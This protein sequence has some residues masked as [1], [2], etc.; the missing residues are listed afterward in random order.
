MTRLSLI[1]IFLCVCMVCGAQEDKTSAVTGPAKDRL[2]VSLNLQARF[3]GD[4]IVLRWGCNSSFAWPILSKTGYWVER[5]MLDEN[6]KPDPLFTRLTPD[7]VRPWSEL[8]WNQKSVQNDLY[9]QVAEKAL[10]GKQFEV[11]AGDNTGA[12]SNKDRSVKSMQQ[13]ASESD[14]RFIAA[15][16]SGSFSQNA[17]TA[18]GLR[19]TDRNVRKNVKYVYRVYP[20][21]VSPLFRTDTAVFI[22]DTKNELSPAPVRYL[23]AYEGDKIISIRWEDPEHYAGYYIE[24]SEDGKVFNKLSETP[25]IQFGSEAKANSDEFTYLDTL[26]INYKNYYYRIRG[27]SLFSEVSEPSEIIVAKGRDREAPMQPFIRKSVYQGGKTAF[28]DWEPYSS[29]PDLLG[30]FVQRG[31][32]IKGPYI[33][34][35][36]EI[37]TPTTRNFTDTAIDVGGMNFYIV[38]AVDT[39]GNLISSTPAYVVVPDNIPPVAPVGLRGSISEKGG[40]QLIWQPNPEKDIKG[41]IV[42][43]ANQ[44]DHPFAP[45]SALVIDTVFYDTVTMNT[46]TKH[47]YFK[48]TA[49][50]KSGNAGE[51]S[52]ILELKRPVTVPPIAPVFS[53]YKSGDGSMN[54]YWVCSSTEDVVKQLLFRKSEGQDWKLIAQFPQGIAYYLDTLVEKRKYYEYALEA[55]DVDSIHSAKSGTLYVQI[56]DSGIRPGIQVLNAKKSKDGK[57]ADL[58]WNYSLKG[59]YE[60]V[61]F[62]SFNGSPKTPIVRIPPNENFY[63]DKHLTN[64]SYQYFIKVQ[65]NNGGASKF[66]ASEILDF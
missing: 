44:A 22:I 31:E 37:L 26:K 55:V 11:G 57:S 15:M 65:Y 24:R 50:D 38:S 46:L 13:T 30:F 6:N 29:V 47:V 10:Y 23:A 28:L 8:E 61:I 36:K 19:F 4:S 2:S 35:N 56:Y 14:Q 41:Y 42:Y 9:L 25:Y 21:S 54:I 63:I 53:N 39:A 3:R 58:S 34:L 64:G 48:I 66:T 59:D 27:I 49:I 43:S 51:F 18:L 32:N 62:R 40:V 1:S 33:L 12:A 16:I 45:E 5:L 52:E 60:F 20:A 7:P 17:A